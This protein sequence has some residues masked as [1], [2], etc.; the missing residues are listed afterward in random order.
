MLICIHT[1]QNT[2][3]R[4]IRNSND[5]SNFTLC[6][7]VKTLLLTYCLFHDHFSI[8]SFQFIYQVLITY[9]IN[10]SCFYVRLL[11]HCLSD[12][13]KTVSMET[14]YVQLTIELH[15]WYGDPTH[16]VCQR[17]LEVGDVC[18]VGNEAGCYSRVKVVS[19]VAK[20]TEESPGTA[21]VRNCDQL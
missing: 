4:I 18:G 10:A 3:I 21:E 8:S 20:A 13:H 5:H 9:V 14:G 16:R 6:S 7:F 2:I 12:D 11:K 15:Q 17:P 19:W 1:G